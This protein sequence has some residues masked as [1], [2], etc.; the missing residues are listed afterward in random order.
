VAH[1]VLQS[2]EDLRDRPAEFSE[3]RMI[4]AADLLTKL[5]ASMQEATEVLAR[6]TETDLLTPFNIQGYKVTGLKAIYQAVEHFATHYGQIV[7]IT[8]LVQA[9][10]LGFYRELDNTGLIP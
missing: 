10:D 5:D 4:P 2:L 7:F 9:K 8:K 3:R 6:I 1:F